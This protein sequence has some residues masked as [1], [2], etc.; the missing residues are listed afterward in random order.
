MAYAATAQLKSA[1][2]Y[3]KMAVEFSSKGIKAMK[4]RLHR[5]KIEDDLK[6]VSAVRDAV[7]DMIILVDA[8][9]V[10][11]LLTITIG[12]EEQL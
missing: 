6:V 5:P 11:C 8:T 4:L 10:I 2:E 1:E 3:A 7:K 12:Q 9:R